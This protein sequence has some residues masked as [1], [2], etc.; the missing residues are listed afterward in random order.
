MRIDVEKY[1]IN[2]TSSDDERIA[3]IGHFERKFKLDEIFQFLNIIKDEMSIVRLS[4]NARKSGVGLYISEEMQ[5]LSDQSGVTDFSSIVFLDE[6]KILENKEDPDLAYNQLIRS[7]K[8]RLS[9][10]CSSKLLF[11]C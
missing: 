11:R 3:R 6:G 7:W 10:I 8:S 2:S 9:L 4:P 5:L 1:G